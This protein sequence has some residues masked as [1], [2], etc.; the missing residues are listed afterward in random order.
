MKYTEKVHAKR[1]IKMLEKPEPCNCC[2]AQLNFKINTGFISGVVGYGWGSYDACRV[3][4]AFIGLSPNSQGCPCYRM[5]RERALELT[6]EALKEKG[7]L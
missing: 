7:Y 4:K 2:P 3:C 5:D 1:L 6:R